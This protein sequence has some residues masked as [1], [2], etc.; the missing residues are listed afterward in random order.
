MRVLDR[1]WNGDEQMVLF[2]DLAWADLQKLIASLNDEEN[3]LLFTFTTDSQWIDF[4]KSKHNKLTYIIFKSCRRRSED[5]A[6]D[7][8]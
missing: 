1:G 8:K 5:S 2:G 4:L 7:D 6:E 3:Q